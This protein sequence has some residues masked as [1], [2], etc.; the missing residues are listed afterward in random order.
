MF[1]V[2]FEAT[3]RTLSDCVI[4]PDF[5]FINMNINFNYSSSCIQRIVFNFILFP[6]YS[7]LHEA[8]SSR[9]FFINKLMW[10]KNEMIYFSPSK[11]YGTV[12]IIDFFW[13]FR[14]DDEKLKFF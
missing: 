14:I 5:F 11:G 13:R 10:Q 1:D 2:D 9:T 3:R 12:G 6:F 4:L 7:V 8:V